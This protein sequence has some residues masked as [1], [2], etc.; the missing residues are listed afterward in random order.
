MENSIFEVWKS[1]YP[2]LADS[3][4]FVFMVAMFFWF[5]YSVRASIKDFKASIDLNAATV[6]DHLDNYNKIHEKSWT[7]LNDLVQELKMGKVWK[8]EYLLKIRNLEDK[9]LARDERIKDLNERVRCIEE[10][11]RQ[12]KK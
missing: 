1:I 5:R 10:S 11:K 12:A 4:L 6:K 3:L 9:G 8:D 7:T 2:T